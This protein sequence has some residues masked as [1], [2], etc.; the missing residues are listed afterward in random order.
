MSAPV[1]V[2]VVS[3][4]TR[5]LLRRCLRSLEPEVEVGRADVWVVD[6]GSSDGSRELVRDEFPTVTLIEPDRNLGFG[7]AVNVVA[8]QTTS[9]WVAPANADI[10]LGEGALERLLEVGNSDPAI[11]CVAPRLGVPDGTT[12]H[13]VYPFPGPV[14]A[15]ATHLAK[16]RVAPR[17]GDRYCLIGGWDPDRPREV[18]WPVGAFMIVRREAWDAVGGF[19][20]SQWM[21]A[22]DLD[23]G[24]RLARAGW[25]RR[26]EPCARV[27]HF[28]SAATG[29]AFGT[30]AHGQDDGGDLRL[31]ATQEGTSIHAGDRGDR[32]RGDGPAARGGRPVRGLGA[33]SLRPSAGPGALL[34]RHPPPGTP[35]GRARR[36]QTAAAAQVAQQLPHQRSLEPGG[37]RK[38]RRHVERELAERHRQLLR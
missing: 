36:D 30:G 14:V 29:E 20:D 2:A 15:L 8:R 31:A 17:L 37:R 5:E 32:H 25:S 11:G 16:P 21:F 24:W 9:D 19:D 13:S 38:R 1:T 34:G 6:N 35:L 18:D 4:N 23:L 10:E 7:P 27:R 28:E 3:W 33:G 12:Q 26:Y 22:E